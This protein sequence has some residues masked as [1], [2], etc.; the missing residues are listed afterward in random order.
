MSIVAIFALRRALESARA[1]AGI[2][3]KWFP[4]G[5]PCLP[6][7]LFQCAGNSIE[8]YVLNN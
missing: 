5:A 4:M 3:E 2:K 6:D 7:T 1:D 8:Q